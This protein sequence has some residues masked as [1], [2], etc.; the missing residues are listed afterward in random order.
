MSIH[1]IVV[2]T[3]FMPKTLI[4]YETTVMNVNPVEA[5]L[6]FFDPVRDNG[7]FNP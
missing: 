3:N 6:P 5:V 4:P 2:F 7:Y 1:E